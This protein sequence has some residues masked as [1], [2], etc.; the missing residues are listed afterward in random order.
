LIS[1]N[2]LHDRIS[3]L[4]VDIRANQIIHKEKSLKWQLIQVSWDYILL[5]NLTGD[6]YI[7][8]VLQPVVPHFDNHPLSTR[9]VYMYRKWS[10]AHARPDMMSPE[11]GNRKWKGNNFSGFLYPYFPRFSSVFPAFFHGT[12]LDSTYEQ[13][14]CESSL[15][16]VTIDL[17]PRL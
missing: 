11:V 14:N 10:C 8:D 9:P 17:L 2:H 16:R 12:P 5:C 15:Y 3:S 13:W 6:Q 7:R 1:W 4:R